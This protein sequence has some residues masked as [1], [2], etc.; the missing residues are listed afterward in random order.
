MQDLRHFREHSLPITFETAAPVLEN[1][2]RTLINHKEFERSLPGLFSLK[3]NPKNAEVLRNALLDNYVEGVWEYKDGISCQTDEDV[4]RCYQKGWLH[5]KLVP[6]KEG[7]G[8]K[9]VYAFPT[10]LH[11]G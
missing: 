3:Y 4:D 10:P 2:L 9:T 6:E 5:A 11:Q 1:R 8:E 7:G